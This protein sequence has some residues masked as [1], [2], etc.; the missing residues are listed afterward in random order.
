MADNSKSKPKAV[1]EAILAEIIIDELEKFKDSH[2]S[3]NSSIAKLLNQYSNV[4]ALMA[5]MD[6][7]DNSLAEILRTILLTQERYAKLLNI[8]MTVAN[9]VKEIQKQGIGIEPNAI[10]KLIRVVNNAN[11]PIRVY[12]ILLTYGVIAAFGLLLVISIL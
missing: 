5:M 6:K 11:R 2:D 8:S 1:Q 10:D 7:C 3:I 9:E 4:N 12:I